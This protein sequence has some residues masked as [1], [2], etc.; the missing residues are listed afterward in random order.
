MTTKTELLNNGVVVATKTAA[1]FYS[2]DWTPATSGASSLTYKRYEDNVLVFTSAAITGTV[3]APAAASLLLDTYSGAYLAYS[4]DKVK[5]SY[6]GPVLRIKK[7]IDPVETFTDIGYSGNYIDKAAITSYLNG[8]D[9]DILI[10]Y[11]GTG[12]GRDWNHISS[13][14][15]PRITTGGVLNEVNGKL[16]VDPVSTSRSV[17]SSSYL[18]RCH[19]Y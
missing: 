13:G 11:D 15:Y 9:G 10:F 4:F 8:D 3:D 18:N 17:K 19:Y 6:N 14:F 7:S 2:W 1:P 12:N 16:W 5:A